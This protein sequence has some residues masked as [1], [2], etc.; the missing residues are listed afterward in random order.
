MSDDPDIVSALACLEALRFG[1]DQASVKGWMDSQSPVLT[2]AIIGMSE[3]YE[4]ALSFERQRTANQK[5]LVADF[6]NKLRDVMSELATAKTT[7]WKLT[8]RIR[9]AEAT[10]AARKVKRRK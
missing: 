7:I 10:A 1:R 2:H 9:A 6:D 5:K 3:R 4:K 8:E